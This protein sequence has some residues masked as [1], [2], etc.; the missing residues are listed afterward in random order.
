MDPL[1]GFHSTMDRPG[2]GESYKPSKDDEESHNGCKDEQPSHH[3]CISGL[4]HVCPP[5]EFGINQACAAPW[6]HLLVEN[7]SKLLIPKWDY[8][9]GG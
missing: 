2:T 6:R 5:I 1:M 8:S 7:G 3:G 9:I 4:E